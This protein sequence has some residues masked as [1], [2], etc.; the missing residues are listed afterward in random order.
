MTSAA[1]LARLI[2]LEQERDNYLRQVDTLH[3]W[4]GQVDPKFYQK[5]PAKWTQEM[6]DAKDKYHAL[7]DAIKEPRVRFFMAQRNRGNLSSHE[8]HYKLAELAM[9]WG[10]LAL[11]YILPIPRHASGCSLRLSSKLC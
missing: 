10:Q 5:D 6:E 3:E 8:H 9:D 1:I 2:P 11:E 4:L 7:M